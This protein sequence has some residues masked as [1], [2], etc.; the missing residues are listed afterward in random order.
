MA[1]NALPQAAGFEGGFIRLGRHNESRARVGF[2]Q[3]VVIVGQQLGLG[4]APH[5]QQAARV[6]GV[7]NAEFEFGGAAL[8]D[9]VEV[10]VVE[11]V[12]V[13]VEVVRQEG[14]AQAVAGEVEHD[15]VVGAG[16][17]E[18]GRHGAFNVLK[19]R[20][21]IDQY[22]DVFVVEGAAFRAFQEGVHLVGVIVGIAQDRHV[23]VRRDAND[24][25]PY[26]QLR[27][28]FL[29]LHRRV[30]GSAGFQ[31]FLCSGIGAVF[32]V[33]GDRRAVLHEKG[34]VAV[35]LG[36]AHFPFV[37]FAIG[38]EDGSP[39]VGQPVAEEADVFV[40]IFENIGAVAILAV[41]VD[42]SLFRACLGAQ[43]FAIQPLAQGKLAVGP[44]QLSPAMGHAVLEIAGIAVAVGIEKNA[45]AIG[46]AISKL[47]FVAAAVDIGKGA[48]AVVAFAGKAAGLNVGSLS[49]RFLARQVSVEEAAI[50]VDGLPELPQAGALAA[51]R[52]G[53]GSPAV[54]MAAHPFALVF[55]A[56]GIVADAVAENLAF[57]KLA[58]VNGLAGENVNAVSIET[59][60]GNA[61]L[62]PVVI[63]SFPAAAAGKFLRGFL[64]HISAFLKPARLQAP[65]AQGFGALAMRQA[66]GP[67]AFVAAA[68]G[69]V[70]NPDSIAFPI[71]E[72]PDVTS[73]AGKTVRALPIAAVAFLALSMEGSVDEK[74][75]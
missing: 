61:A 68:V 35:E 58:G 27:R 19:G 26:F 62:H 54:G 14:A 48:A 9:G 53:H 6:A 38:V 23:V 63:A 64:S 74:A 31:W 17:A 69:P 24:H 25:C 15:E 52:I 7:G 30:G 75:G 40:A 70:T 42:A 55:A 18:E 13:A 12:V 51:V 56:I 60:A 3:A 57:L 59:I 47:A 1:E 73:P 67:F 11:L 66:I 29:L 8:H 43:V 20:L 72:L 33:P 49:F 34:S 44:P 65:Q 28:L 46:F 4:A 50:F 32:P 71:F 2:G 21:F 41:A 5:G 22:A 36:V 45:K 37:S 16:L 39:A 10:F